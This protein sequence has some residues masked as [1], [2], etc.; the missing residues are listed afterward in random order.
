MMKKYIVTD[1]CYILPQ[2]TWSEC[3][4]KCQAL[5]EEN[6][7]DNFSKIVQEALKDF[8]EG[9]QVFVSD[10]GFGDWSNC[11]YGPNTEE[12]CGFCADAG[13]VCVC[14]YTG[15]VPDALGNLVKYGAAAAFYAEGPIEVEFDTS[16]PNWTI[17]N[18]EDADGNCWC[19]DSGMPE[20]EE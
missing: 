17:V 9:G 20:D 12:G 13:M 11:L 2:D 3:C 8:A 7:S 5:G 14:A 15:K 18:I 6:W 1:P 19:T 10:T 16:D 4:D